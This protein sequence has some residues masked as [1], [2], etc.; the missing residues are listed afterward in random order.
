MPKA[1]K[2][3]ISLSDTPYYH[4]ISRCVRADKRGLIKSDTPEILHKLGLDAYTWVETVQGFSSQFHTFIVPEE[5]LK[6]VCQKQTKKW[7]RGVRL[8]RR[9]FNKPDPC[10][11]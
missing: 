2:Q 5:Q 9:L 4:C 8:C 6:A 3:Q 11:V 7:L 10:P 1:R